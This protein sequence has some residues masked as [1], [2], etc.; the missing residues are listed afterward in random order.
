MHRLQGRENKQVDEDACCSHGWNCFTNLSSRCSTDC[1][2]QWCPCHFTVYTHKQAQEGGQHNNVNTQ[3]KRDVICKTC[4]SVIFTTQ[5]L[6]LLTIKSTLN[7]HH[8]I[9]HKFSEVI[10]ALLRG[11]DL[12]IQPENWPGCRSHTLSLMS[13]MIL[14]NRN[15]CNTKQMHYFVQAS[16]PLYHHMSS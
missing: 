13:F 4:V 6:Q 1:S 14:F 16:C 7:S 11:L 12:N 3:Q 5:L 8:Y 15:I 2:T 9:I 10:A